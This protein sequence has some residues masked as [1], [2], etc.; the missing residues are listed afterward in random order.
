[1]KPH[2]FLDSDGVF[3][4]FDQHIFNLFGCYPRE[5]DDADMW[6][7]ANANPE[8][9]SDMPLKPGALELWEAVIHTKPTVLTGCPKSDYDR[10]VTHKLAWWERHFGHTQVITC[11]SR[12]K[13]L[14]M[15]NPGDWLVDD[16]VKNCKRW[17]KA[18]GNAFVYRDNPTRVI[19]VLRGVGA[20]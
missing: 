7:K 11:L 20:L 19:E 1:M 3:A 5:M 9:W 15:K 8:F 6:A 14:H 10:A 13:A 4:D 16:M 17:E 12:D 18:G 2:L